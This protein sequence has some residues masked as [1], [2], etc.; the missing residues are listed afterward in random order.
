MFKMMRD[1]IFNNPTEIEPWIETK[2]LEIAS[3]LKH[4]CDADTRAD[5][6]S[7]ADNKLASLILFITSALVQNVDLER[8][9]S[10]IT[11]CGTNG[12]KCH[13]IK[14]TTLHSLGIIKGYL[15]AQRKQNANTSAGTEF[16]TAQ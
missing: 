1:A 7:R 9:K 3:V 11:P 4:I 14:F 15:E 6:R 13:E 16:F 12:C 10:N 8:V 2:T 5:V